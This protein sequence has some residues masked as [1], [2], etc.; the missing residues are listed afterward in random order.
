MKTF[1][2]EEQISNCTFYSYEYIYNFYINHDY[3]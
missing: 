2:L 3:I 1:Q